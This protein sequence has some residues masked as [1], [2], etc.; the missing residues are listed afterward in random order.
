MESTPALQS[1][2]FIKP[3]VLCESQC[4]D[5][6]KQLQQHDNVVYLDSADHNSHASI[7]SVNRQAS[8]SVFAWN[9]LYLIETTSQQSTVY[10]RLGQP[11]ESSAIQPLRL[12]DKYLK[13]LPCQQLSQANLS[14]N[15]PFWGGALGYWGYELGGM[16]ES[17]PL[18][19]D[20]GIDLPDMLIGIY[21]SAIIID[22]RNQHIQ[23]V[24]QD[25]NADK[26]YNQLINKINNIT[27]QSSVT[28]ASA[29]ATIAKNNNTS[30]F[31]ILNHWLANMSLDEYQQ[32][33]DAIQEYLMAGDCYQIN[34][35]QRFNAPYSGCEWQ[36][37]QHLRANNKAPFSCFMRHK[38][39]VILSLS[40]ERFLQVKGDLIETKPIKGT[41]PRHTDSVKDRLLASELQIAEKDRSENLMIVDLLRNDLSKVAIKGSVKVPQL[42]GI[43]SYP[44]VHHLVSTITAKLKVDSTS[45]D[46]L[47]GAFPGGSITGA[48]KIRA[49]QI[50]HQL[51]P[52]P[53]RVYCGAIGYIL[54]N[55]DM[56]TNIAIRTLVCHQQ[57]IYCWAGG[58]IVADSKVES[59]YQET[60]DKVN[61]ILPLLSDYFG[62]KSE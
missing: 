37:Y 4:S 9:P 46:L 39:N 24:S 35:A 50:I 62:G 61:K 51:E 43:E 38:S 44:A 59:E 30:D 40:P 41:R 25:P 47:A 15:L 11:I 55:G 29:E 22:H 58:G 21:D 1:N 42:F 32:K 28:A 5:L 56:D 18:A 12:I 48:P 16:F 34:L 27:E 31:K 54:A 57:Q 14:A 6:F 45:L 2:L 7:D 10:N 33:F 60:L 3:L 36:A 8:F 23:F 13:K 49:M 19:K 53:R 26:L 20:D 17:L 52:H